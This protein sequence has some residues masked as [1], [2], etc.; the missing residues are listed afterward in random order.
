V[1]IEITEQLKH[2]DAQNKKE[3]EKFS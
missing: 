1:F 2:A 3:A